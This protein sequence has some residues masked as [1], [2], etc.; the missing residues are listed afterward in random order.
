MGDFEE[1]E[2]TPIQ[3]RAMTVAESLVSA[4]GR[5]PQLRLVVETL[6]ES[7]SNANEWKWTCELWW[8]I[9]TVMQ[10][11]S[12]EAT[13]VVSLTDIEAEQLAQALLFLAPEDTDVR[14]MTTDRLV[15]L[16][17]A[18]PMKQAVDFVWHMCFRGVERARVAR[19]VAHLAE[20]QL[21]QPPMKSVA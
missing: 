1:Q 14:K 9:M 11:I 15:P 5:C 8:Q 3:L 12:H 18:L 4:L 19:F 6:K 7:A 21:V 20:L 13:P 16:T 2:M 10:Y 17:Q